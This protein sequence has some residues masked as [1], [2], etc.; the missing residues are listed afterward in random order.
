MILGDRIDQPA[1]AVSLMVFGWG[2]S[3]KGSS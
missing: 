1:N 3:T 2:Y